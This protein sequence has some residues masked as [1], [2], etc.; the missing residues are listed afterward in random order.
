MNCE[1]VVVRI[2]M[3]NNFDGDFKVCTVRNEIGL[4]WTSDGDLRLGLR[5]VPKKW[6]VTLALGVMYAVYV[7]W[8]RE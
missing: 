2:R 4:K 7:M 8:E 5:M 1:P 3:Q 6:L